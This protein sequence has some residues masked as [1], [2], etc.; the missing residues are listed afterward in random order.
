[1]GALGGGGGGGKKRGR[2]GREGRK[3]G[4]GGG[5]GGGR[6]GGRD[7]IEVGREIV[8]SDWEEK[9]EGEMVARRRRG[10]EEGYEGGR[11]VWGRGRG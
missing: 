8:V 3:E 11:G 2:E 10:E 1:M 7:R 5:G 4:G 9:E 6:D